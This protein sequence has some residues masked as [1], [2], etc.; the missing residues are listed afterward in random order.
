[1]RWCLYL[2]ITG[3]TTKPPLL[4]NILVVIINT[5]LSV[6]YHMWTFVQSCGW[7]MAIWIWLFSLVHYI[8]FYLPCHLWI[9]MICRHMIRINT[10]MMA[11]WGGQ[12]DWF[13]AATV[14][15]SGSATLL[16]TKSLVWRN[17]INGSAERREL[18]VV[19][20]KITL[21]ITARIYYCRNKVACTF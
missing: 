8:W 10:K 21:L 15:K 12:M 19:W 18:A 4:L 9:S 11:T 5:H 3:V 6:W 7:Q 13:K 2:Q 1:M 16:S 14:C 20:G 17:L